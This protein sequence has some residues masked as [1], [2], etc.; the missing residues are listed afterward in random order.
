MGFQSLG[1]AI[2]YLDKFQF[3]GFRLGLERIEAALKALG[4]PQ[5]SYPTIHVAGTNGKGSVCAAL[6]SILQ[7]AGYKVGFYSS[8]HLVRLNERFRIDMMPIGDSLL[9]GLIEE[10]ASL[11]ENG[12]ELSYFEF[13][14]AMAFSCFAKCKVDF[15]VIETGL[16]G[17]LD[18]TNVVLPLLSIITNI[19]L[20]HQSYL[21]RN[22]EQ[23]A[24]EKAGI[25][26]GGIPVVAGELEKGP[27][28]TISRVCNKKNAPLYL[29]GRDFSIKT[30][31]QTDT[32]DFTMGG[33]QLK[34]ASF[35]LMGKF[36]M[37]NA[38]LAVASARILV[39]KGLP[40]NHA[41]LR[42]GLARTFWPGRNELL[43]GSMW[44]LLDGAHNEAGIEVLKD[45]VVQLV[46]RLQLS[47]KRILLWACTNEG[48]DKDPLLMLKMIA[49]LFQKIFITEPQG[50]RMPVSVDEWRFLKKPDNTVLVKDYK[51]AIET[52]FA[53]SREGTLLVIAGSLYLVGPARQYLLEKGFKQVHKS[54]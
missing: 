21:G 5:T 24:F 23:I 35:G 46:N 10:T 6:S 43:R 9:K 1:D 4:N 27:L 42:Q 33:F 38:A 51:E 19:S 45:S 37:E 31:P 54:T 2:S 44:V 34:D 8:P 47:G 30:H 36:Q 49:P 14:T 41:N 17:R 18:A 7:Q 53:N 28:K 29:L 3:H 13:T 50:P 12:L 22:L 20:D 39:D 11:V 25:I 52:V 32:F 15:A 40:I 48:K 16:G 26:K